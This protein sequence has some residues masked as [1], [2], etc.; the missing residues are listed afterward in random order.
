MVYISSAEVWVFKGDASKFPGELQMDIKSPGF[1]TSC[2]LCNGFGGKNPHSYVVV[3][4]PCSVV[5]IKAPSRHLANPAE[6]RRVKRNLG[7]RAENASNFGKSLPNKQYRT[8]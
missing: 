5:V 8:K 7:I 4:D 6:K 1:E 2:L 3:F